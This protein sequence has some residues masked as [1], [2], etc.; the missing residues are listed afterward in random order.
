MPP[1]CT[2]AAELL[3]PSPSGVFPSSLSGHGEGDGG[4]AC[5]CPQPDNVFV[6]AGTGDASGAWG[7]GLKGTAE[8]PLLVVFGKRSH[9]VCR[10]TREGNQT[11]ELQAE[12]TADRRSSASFVR[13]TDVRGASSRIL[14]VQRPKSREA[15]MTTISWKWARMDP[16]KTASSVCCDRPRSHSV[17]LRAFSSSVTSLKK[18]KTEAAA[19]EEEKGPP[20][21]VPVSSVVELSFKTVQGECVSSLP[22][23]SLSSLPF[24]SPGTR[25]EDHSLSFSPLKDAGRP[26]STERKTRFPPH[27][28][29]LS[30]PSGLSIISRS[31]KGAPVLRQ[32]SIASST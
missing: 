16:W 22:V 7:G 3:R 17:R 23:A 15:S 26:V 6:C 24:V 20:L 21:P 13:K 19:E 30:C 25:Q 11:T 32:L 28:N 18:P 31:A 27:S 5:H 12:N 1:V 29:H 14:P 4:G 9:G 10:W 8:L 2:L